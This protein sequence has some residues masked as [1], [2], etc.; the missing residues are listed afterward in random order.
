MNP[1][2]WAKEPIKSH[3]YKGEIDRSYQDLPRYSITPPGEPGFVKPSKFSLEKLQE[4]HPGAK[5]KRL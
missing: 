3:V 1:T 2:N 4:L 5:I